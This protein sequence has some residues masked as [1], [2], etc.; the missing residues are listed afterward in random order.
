MRACVD[1]CEPAWVYIYLI[2]SVPTWTRK[3]MSD[4]LELELEMFVCCLRL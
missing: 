1:V 4:L 3:M 2:H